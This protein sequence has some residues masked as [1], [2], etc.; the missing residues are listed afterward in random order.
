MKLIGVDY[1]H[2]QSKTRP[3][4]RVLGSQ[5]TDAIDN[6]TYDYMVATDSEE[7]AEAVANGAEP[8]ARLLSWDEGM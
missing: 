4:A 7:E 6:D 1:R 8:G 2:D 3:A 5:R